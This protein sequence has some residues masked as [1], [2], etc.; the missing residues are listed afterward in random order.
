MDI[1]ATEGKLFK[2]IKQSIRTNGSAPYSLCRATFSTPHGKV[3][4]HEIVLRYNFDHDYEL[5]PG[6]QSPPGLLRRE[7]QTRGL[8]KALSDLSDAQQDWL[9]G[10]L[11]AYYPANRAERPGWL[12][13]NA[14]VDFDTSPKY[15]D[16]PPYAVWRTDLIDRI[17]QWIL[18]VV[19]DSQLY[20]IENVSATIDGKQRMISIPAPGGHRTV[21]GHLHGILSHI[22]RHGHANYTNARLAIGARTAGARSV[23]VMATLP[24]GEEVTVAHQLQD[25]SAGELMVFCLFA[26]LIHLAERCGWNGRNIADISGV[27][28]V[29]ELDL[30]LHIKL[31]KEVVPL[32][33]KQMPKVQFIITSHS[34]FLTLG[35]AEREVD[36]IRMPDA[37]GIEVEDFSEFA[38]AY[39]TFLAR[40][41][42]HMVQ[43]RALEDEVRTSSRPLIVTEGKTDW[44]HFKHALTRL[45]EV[46]EYGELDVEF[47]ETETD[48][49]DGE[50]MKCLRAFQTVL[51]NRVMIFVFDRDNAETVRKITACMAHSM[52]GENAVGMCIEVPE[53][54]QEYRNICVEHLYSDEALHT[55]IAGTQKRLRLQREIGYKADRKTAFVLGDAQGTDLGIVSKDVANI[56]WIDGSDVGELAISKSAFLQEIVL[57]DA[58]KNFD[59]A[60]FRPTLDKIQRILSREGGEK[61]G[62]QA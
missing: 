51:P 15:V 26:D 23:S 39:E 10:R 33:I 46:G 59:L 62:D 2:P 18:D 36:I 54:R 41:Q 27:V 16:S 25:L 50:L 60:G 48:M 22:I 37:K 3:D 7:F 34:P 56:G 49:G 45:R 43:L 5:P 21:V 6:V 32:L 29:D 4:F 42:I 20:D 31:Q 11:I 57:G 19:L 55:F 44:R 61:N 30:H 52:D 17:S 24:S 40:E 8:S 9:R 13:E 12:G 14:N 53:H 1:D 28:L 47:F 35:M 38:T 58:G